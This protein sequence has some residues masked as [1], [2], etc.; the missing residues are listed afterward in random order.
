MSYLS[1]FGEFGGDLGVVGALVETCE[2]KADVMGDTLV[3][4]WAEISP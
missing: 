2:T 4:V 3:D 1:V